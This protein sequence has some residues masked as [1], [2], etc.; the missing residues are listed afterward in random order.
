MRTGLAAL[1]LAGVLVA[2]AAL[3]DPPVP[4]PPSAHPPSAEP[5]SAAALAAQQQAAVLAFYPPAARAA[6]IEGQ[7][8]IR[9]TRNAHM[10]MQACTLVSETPA[11]QGFGAAAL[12]MAARS[13]DNPKLDFAD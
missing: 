12:A 13:P 11:G 2:G 9:C 4:S 1:G 10:A 3:A 8:T 5:P 6:G 7:A